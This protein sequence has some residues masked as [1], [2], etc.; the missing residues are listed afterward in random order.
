MSRNKLSRKYLIGRS[1]KNDEFDCPFDLVIVTLN[2]NLD[3]AIFNMADNLY[4]SLMKI[5]NENAC[6]HF[7]INFIR[8]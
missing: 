5:F 8:K 2:N 3:F 1:Y 7:H 4:R 6:R